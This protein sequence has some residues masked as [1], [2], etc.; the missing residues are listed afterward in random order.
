MSLFTSIAQ[1]K[2]SLSPTAQT[3]IGDP[4]AGLGG[5]QEKSE[6][7]KTMDENGSGRPIR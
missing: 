2:R 3:Q 6:V 7:P 5:A 1:T 4:F